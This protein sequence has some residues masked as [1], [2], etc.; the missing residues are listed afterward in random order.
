[1]KCGLFPWRL[2]WA[3]LVAKMGKTSNACKL[4]MGKLGNFTWKA[5][6]GMW[7]CEMGLQETGCEDGG[8]GMDGTSL[9]LSSV[10]GFCIS[11]FEPSGYISTVLVIC[12]GL[13][14]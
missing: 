13:T 7:E 8:E 9:D 2:Q 11:G 6:K 10:L 1:M 5:K 14:K 4:L 3:V 12:I